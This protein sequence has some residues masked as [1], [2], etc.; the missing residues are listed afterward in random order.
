MSEQRHNMRPYKSCA[1]YL[2]TA[3]QHSGID[4]FSQLHRYGTDR[5]TYRCNA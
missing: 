4:T 5:Q 3:H 2:N 1:I